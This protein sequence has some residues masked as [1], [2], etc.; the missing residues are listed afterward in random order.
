MWKN[1]FKELTPDE[2]QRTSG[3]AQTCN[4]QTQMFIFGWLVKIFC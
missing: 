2:L 1:K 4:W 3:G